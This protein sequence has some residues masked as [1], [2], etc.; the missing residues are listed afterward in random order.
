MDEKP[1]IICKICEDRFTDYKGLHRHLRAHNCLVVDYYHA[2]YPRKD[3]LTG[4]LIKFKNRKQYLYSH[5]NTRHSMKKWT[6]VT[7]KKDVRNY[8]ESYLKRRAKK[9][10]LKFAPCEVEARSLMCPPITY[11]NSTFDDN[12]YGYCSTELGLENKYTKWPGKISLPF[13]API[14]AIK[15]MRY[16][17]YIDSREQK[18]FKLSFPTEV[19][20]LKYGDYAL[21][22][23]RLSGN[24]YIERKSITD[25]I[26]TLSGGYDRFVKEIERS[27]KD[28]VRLVV[29]VE[30]SINDCLSFKHLPYVS[31]KIKATPE[32]VFHN[33]RTL[34]QTYKNLD[35]LFVRGRKEATRVTEKLLLN[36]RVYS[37]IDLQLAYDIKKL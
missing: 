33:V 14:D 19:K 30:E 27:E 31:K 10:K 1:K 17:I 9:K 32:F 34:L 8:C 4:D 37:K 35:F 7:P 22:D 23:D 20:A 2:Y 26:G 5:F 28:K 11:L 36:G 15:K 13:D 25:F 21:D 6:Q 16:K 12:Y 3:L 18:P 29:L 24:T